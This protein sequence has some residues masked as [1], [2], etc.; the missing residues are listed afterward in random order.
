MPSHHAKQ[1]QAKKKFP[2]CGK[3]ASDS[4]SGASRKRSTPNCTHTWA[5]FTLHVHPPPPQAEYRSCMMLV[6][7][8]EKK[9][10]TTIHHPSDPTNNKA[11]VCSLAAVHAPITRWPR[12]QPPLWDGVGRGWVVCNTVLATVYAA[13][14]SCYFYCRR[15]GVSEGKLFLLSSR[16]V[17]IGFTLVSSV[18]MV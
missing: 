1:M 8:K 14:C 9:Q 3:P 11:A 4:L 16:L 6:R 17:Y 5:P 18:A 7:R 2:N 13:L 10:H 15:F 12:D